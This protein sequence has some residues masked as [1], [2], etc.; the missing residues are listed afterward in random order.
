MA[1]SE[2]EERVISKGYL[3]NNDNAFYVVIVPVPG[4][5]NPQPFP[6]E[7]E[8]I[9]DSDTI[10]FR[11]Q[12]LFVQGLRD[13]TIEFLK[14]GMMHT[15]HRDDALWNE[16]LALAPYAGAFDNEA[17]VTLRTLFKAEGMDFI[18]FMDLE[19]EKVGLSVKLDIKNQSL[20]EAEIKDKFAKAIDNVI[21]QINQEDPASKRPSLEERIRTIIEE[22]E[23]EED[24]DS[25]GLGGLGG[26]GPLQGGLTGVGT[27][28]PFE[29]AVQEENAS[30]SH[31][32]VDV[33]RLLDGLLEEE[34]EEGKEDEDKEQNKEENNVPKED[35]NKFF[36][37]K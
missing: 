19:Q 13:A 32:D 26:Q 7:I 24:F 33:L 34:E 12:R 17:V 4:L 31:I 30:E 37:R 6:D 20:T 21:V 36:K 22:S 9:E 15:F 23:R 29:P 14:D 11:R 16:I 3:I 35:R 25:L 28:S 18:A 1:I 2:Q 8:P 27:G 5:Q 10:F